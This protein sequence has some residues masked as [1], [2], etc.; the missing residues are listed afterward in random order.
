MTRFHLTPFSNGTRSQKASKEKG[1][2]L[3]VVIHPNIA[4]DENQVERRTAENE[5]RRLTSESTPVEQG[6]DFATSNGSL[7]R[8]EMSELSNISIEKAAT[9]GSP[10]D[11]TMMHGVTGKAVMSSSFSERV[12]NILGNFFPST[13]G[14]GTGD[15]LDTHRRRTMKKLMILVL[16]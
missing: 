8:E 12:K 13:M 10:T 2:M 9:A 6:H 14:S 3:E 16:K 15:E 11:N 1:A 7:D 5:N 4:L